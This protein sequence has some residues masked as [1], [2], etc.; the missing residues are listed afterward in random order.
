M[1]INV[2]VVSSVQE[3]DRPNS[4]YMLFYERSAILE[5]VHQAASSPTAPAE[6]EA[7]ATPLEQ[8]RTGSRNPQ[9]SS[10]LQSPPEQSH[11][12]Q[13]AAK[14]PATHLA[15]LP[16]GSPMLADASAASSPQA[17]HLETQESLQEHSQSSPAAALKD[18]LSIGASS[19]APQRPKSS[20]SGSPSVLPL[21]ANL[22][23]LKVCHSVCTGRPASA[24]MH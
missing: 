11:S 6:V 18:H 16:A 20:A 13:Q 8:Q 1:F 19:P 10:L 17:A 5:P 4:A 22:S 14:V 24:V 12:P 15:D 21:L 2:A 9:A 3:Y 23:P 7:E